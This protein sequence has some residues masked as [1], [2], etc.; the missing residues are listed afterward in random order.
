MHKCILNHSR[1]KAVKQ[2]RTRIN[3]GGSQ[4]S[5]KSN[6]IEATGQINNQF[7]VHKP[8]DIQSNEIFIILTILCVLRILEV[9]YG[10]YATCK[11]RIQRRVRENER[12][13]LSQII[14]QAPMP[15]ARP[16][17]SGHI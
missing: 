10:L 17:G 13:H 2:S 12:L 5:E 1:R 7:V 4:S 3:M 9:A 16:N 15:T 8:V 11:R 14:P 6:D